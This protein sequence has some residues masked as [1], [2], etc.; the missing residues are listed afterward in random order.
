MTKGATHCKNC[1]WQVS[2]YSGADKRKDKAVERIERY[3]FV[4]GERM[5]KEGTVLQGFFC[6]EKGEALASKKVKEADE[7]VL[8]HSKPGDVLGI[9]SYVLN[10][11]LRYSAYACNNVAAC[12]VTLK[13]AS[14]PGYQFP[15]TL[16]KLTRSVCNMINSIQK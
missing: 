10:E 1:L 13:S 5:L 2:F 12:F 3:K 8:W 9:E 6:L 16:I 11:K 14:K 7:L 4:K 15:E